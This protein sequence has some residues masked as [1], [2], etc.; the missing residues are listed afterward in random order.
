[1]IFGLAVPAHAATTG[2]VTSAYNS[3]AHPDVLTVYLLSDVPVTSVS[4]TLKP[5]RHT[6]A[7]PVQVTDFT[8][9]EH[10]ADGT[11]TATSASVK[12]SVFDRYAVVVTAVDQNGQQLTMRYGYADQYYFS[13]L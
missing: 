6:G 4:A 7:D 1:M 13:W 3:D 12:P 8:L 5:L 10:A 9:G 11:Q 2:W